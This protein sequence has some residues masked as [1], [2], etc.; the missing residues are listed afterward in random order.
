MKYEDVEKMFK[1]KGFL[2]FKG[3]MNLNIFAKRKV[4]NTN[5][6]DDEFYMVYQEGGKNIVKVWPCTTE[7]GKTYL[8]K[9]MNKDGTFIIKEGQ[10]RGAYTF[11]LHHG[12]Y[13]CLRQY[14][15]IEGFRDNTKD[16]KHDLKGKVFEELAYTNI[17][18]AGKDSAQVDSWS[19]G[20]V[21][22]KRIKDFDEMML[23]AKKSAKVYGDKFTFTMI[24]DYKK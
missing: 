12:K 19:A 15:A 18:H 8:L 22:L 7:S 21:V 6:F 2:F 16:S 10:Y 3:E 9:P 1:S 4:I 23:I 20:C 24:D 14:K 17:H 13:E 5:S 11:G